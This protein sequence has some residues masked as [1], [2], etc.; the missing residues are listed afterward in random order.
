MEPV[1]YLA[2][3]LRG[4]LVDVTV[5]GKARPV[6]SQLVDGRMV[7]AT[8]LLIPPGRDVHLR[9]RY[10]VPVTTDDAALRATPGVSPFAASVR[11]ASCPWL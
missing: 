6:N 3:P 11:I 10:V 5:D 4:G 2:A 7:A 1:V 8:T 9:A